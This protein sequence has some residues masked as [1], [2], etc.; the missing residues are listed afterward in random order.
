MDSTQLNTSKLDEQTDWSIRMSVL[1]QKN[2][3][4]VLW[5]PTESKHNTQGADYRTI[6][7]LHT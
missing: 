3:S 1:C 4:E 7:D 5:C 2:T 6:V